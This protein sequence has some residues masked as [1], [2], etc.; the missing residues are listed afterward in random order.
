MYTGNSFDQAVNVFG[1]KYSPKPHTVAIPATMDDFI[2]HDGVSHINF[3]AN[4]KNKLHTVLVESQSIRKRF[5]AKAQE[6]D[7]HNLPSS[8][9]FYF[10][11][12]YGQ[13]GF[14]HEASMNLCIV[15]YTKKFEKS[16]SNEKMQDFKNSAWYITFMF[17]FFWAIPITNKQSHLFLYFIISLECVQGSLVLYQIYKCYALHIA[18]Q[19]FNDEIKNFE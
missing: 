13:Q 16:V 6:Q 19:K 1:E 17:L 18:Y 10:N 5:T 9:P 11:Q 15:E 3:L 14:D 4:V 8:L 7:V 2:K 12:F